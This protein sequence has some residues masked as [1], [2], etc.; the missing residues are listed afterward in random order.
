MAHEHKS[1][2]I[3]DKLETGESLAATIEAGVD[4]VSGYIIQP[5]QEEIETAESMEI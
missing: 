4:Y 5:P 2:V 1:L 3:A